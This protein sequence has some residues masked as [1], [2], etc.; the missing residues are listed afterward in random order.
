MGRPHPSLAAWATALLLLALPAVGSVPG[1]L[2]FQGLLLD[3]G[4]QPVTGSADLDFALFATATGGTALWSESHTGVAVQ[5]GVYQVSLG[6]TTPL[7]PA[8]LAGGS[9]HLEISVD[10][11]TLAPRQRL[12]APLALLLLLYR[13]LLPARRKR[14]LFAQHSLGLGTLLGGHKL[15]AVFRKA[16]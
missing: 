8:L 9:L 6:A 2:S 15:L 13:A 12:L 11:N 4:G 7:T 16:R 10:G 5:D 3:A 14:D 1:Q